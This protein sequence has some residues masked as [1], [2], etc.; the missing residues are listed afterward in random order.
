MTKQELGVPDEGG[1]RTFSGASTIKP[2]PLGRHTG[3]Q[4]DTPR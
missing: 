4:R 3:S 1:T 2:A